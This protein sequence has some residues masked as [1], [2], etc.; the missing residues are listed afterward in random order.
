MA[1]LSDNP[2]EESSWAPGAQGRGGW[3]SETFFLGWIVSI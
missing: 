1:E 3:K 2:T